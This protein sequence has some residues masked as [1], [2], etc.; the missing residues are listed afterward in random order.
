MN[1]IKKTNLSS[2]N[3]ENYLSSNL[4][5]L[6]E[7]NCDFNNISECHKNQSII[8]D[9]ATP[10]EFTNLTLS[11]SYQELPDEK[12]YDVYPA[13]QLPKDKKFLDKLPKLVLTFVK[14]ITENNNELVQISYDG[15]YSFY[16]QDVRKTY[17]NILHF[18]QDK[19][20][21]HL[22]ITD[23]DLNHQVMKY[24]RKKHHLNNIHP[25]KSGDDPNIHFID[26]CPS[27]SIQPPTI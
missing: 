17:D 8:I 7:I 3:L 4:V 15:L 10:F 27:I 16:T 24:P 22:E 25:L 6:E 2:N 11:T 26:V 13:L 12:I 23:R 18:I 1:L 5:T 19:L 14:P 9:S 20:D 21:I